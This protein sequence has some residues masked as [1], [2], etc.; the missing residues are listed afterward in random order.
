MSVTMDAIK[1]VEIAGRTPKEI[2]LKTLEILKKFKTVYKRRNRTGQFLCRYV[3]IKLSCRC[4][5]QLLLWGRMWA[6]K[7]KWNNRW[8]RRACHL[9]LPQEIRI[10][11]AYLRLHLLMYTQIHPTALAPCPCPDLFA[12]KDC[13]PRC[14]K[15]CVSW[16]QM[17]AARMSLIVL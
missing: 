16:T 1:D 8:T 12:G 9:C 13:Q 4:K 14:C 11:D 15:N 10:Q 17:K 7:G 6:W 5:R 2:R 3:T